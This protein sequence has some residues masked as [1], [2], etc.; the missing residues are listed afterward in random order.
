[1]AAPS[2]HPD[3]PNWWTQPGA[4]RMSDAEALMWRLEQ[5]PHLSSTFA[6]VAILDR[7]PDLVRLRD[8]LAR[9]VARVPRLRQRVQ[10]PALV[11]G[12]P[13]W[14][15]DPTF[16][17]ANHLRHLALPAPGTHRA[18]FDLVT[19]LV[20]DPFDRTRPLWTFVVIEGLEGGRAAL[21]QK[22]HHTIA[23]GAA[24][25][26]LAMEFLEL[27]RDAPTPPAGDGSRGDADGPSTWAAAAAPGA[28]DA[29]RDALTGLAKAS[30]TVASGLTAAL[31]EPARVPEAGVVAYDRA[32]A[33]VAQLSDVEPARSPLWR[34]RSLQRRV[35]TLQVP[36]RPAKDAAAALGGTVNT[37][38][39]AAAAD[40]AGSY[41]RRLGTPVDELRASFAVSSRTEAS[42]SNAFTLARVL[43][44]TG[45]MD[46]AERFRVVAQ[47]AEAARAASGGASFD[48]LAGLTALLPTPVLTR[49]AR[50]QSQ[51]VDI[52]TSNVRGS[53]FPVFVAGAELLAVYP[54]GPL[55]G[56]A[57]NVTLLSYHGNLDV[58]VHV[59]TAAVAEPELLRDE[60]AA[61]FARLLEV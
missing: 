55:G 56:V 31:R 21:V 28:V 35:E 42:G 15:D 5:D 38:F 53:P 9:V 30:A 61:A 47:R 59:D 2:P 44:P 11:V 4:A 43:V 8:R 3:A 40:A 13:V 18:L 26:E 17:V 24:G 60:V 6:S 22:L 10:A 34:A 57:C 41:H 16:D 50:L 33:V 51:T 20:A 23:D 46:P 25:V 36:F 58:G 27:E 54:V 37:L 14:V 49:L 7:A 29:L 45:E 39:V 12:P 1:M 48:L 19:T 32:R 52:A